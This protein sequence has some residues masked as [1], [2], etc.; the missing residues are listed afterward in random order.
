MPLELPT[1]DELRYTQLVEE[2]RASIPTHYPGWTDHNPSE[3]GIVLMEL[4]AWLTETVLY[5]TN[6]VSDESYRVFL[7]LL[8]GEAPSASQELREATLETIRG[9][10]ERYR[11]VT[12]G[13]YEYLVHHE[14]PRW[15]GFQ[16]PLPVRVR[17]LGERNCD[18][19]A[20]VRH[21]VAPGHVSVVLLPR[22]TEDDPWQQPEP[23]V[24]AR[25]KAF[26]NERR[27]LTT[28]LHVVGPAYVSV[29]VKATLYLE[30]SV[31]VADVRQRAGA[32]LARHFHPLRG[33]ADG[34]GWP[35]GRN[36]YV[37][38]VCTLLEGV[39]GVDFVKDVELTVDGP[40][41]Q[42]REEGR[43]VAVRLFDDE[44]PRLALPD[45]TF[46]TLEKRGGI[47]VPVEP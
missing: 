42:E 28:R 37:S 25:V 44:L 18:A 3:P 31:R 14:Y 7:K 13:D 23:A 46:T 45:M 20:A 9:I 21:Q 11:A 27:L 47:S 43:L 5:R 2:A 41:R 15:P 34:Q 17:C 8:S 33:G 12:P 16:P 10:R 39:R 30:E 29:S 35:L 24:L 6:Q 22:G 32:A 4:L 1:L 19:E 26:L 40:A 38:E 36:L